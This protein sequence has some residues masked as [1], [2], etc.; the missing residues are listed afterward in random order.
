VFN[1]ILAIDF[2]KFFINFYNQFFLVAP[3]LISLSVLV[4]IFIFLNYKKE[5]NVNKILIIFLTIILMQ[6]LFY[7][8]KSQSGDIFTGSVG[9]T[10]ARYLLI[11]WGLLIVLSVYAIKK[12]IDKKFILIVLIIFFFFSGLNKGLYSNMAIKYFIDTSR[13][14]NNLKEEIAARTPENSIFFTSF[15]EKYIYPVRQTAVYV[16]IPKDEQVDKTLMLMK[17]LLENGYSIYIVDERDEW[18]ISPTRDRKIFEKEG[19]S[20]QYVFGGN[21]YK[22]EKRD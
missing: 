11:S 18:A 16:A 22:V 19:L 2:H 14:A 20:V 17:N 7:L 3:L 8:G 6:F 21:I 12:L 10:Y 13:W 1:F 5:R 4:L 15:Y 9:T